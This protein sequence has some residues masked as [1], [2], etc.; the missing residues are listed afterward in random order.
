M[1]DCVEIKI[2]IVD[3][4]VEFTSYVRFYS[5]VPHCEPFVET[6]NA[7]LGG[8]KIFIKSILEKID[9]KKRQRLSKNRQIILFIH[10]NN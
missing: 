9:F 3:F 5:W 1:D 7:H 6:W 10:L 2:Q 8:I 4:I